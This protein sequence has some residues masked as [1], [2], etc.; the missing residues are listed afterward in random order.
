MKPLA[1]RTNGF[2]FAHKTAFFIAGFLCWQSDWQAGATSLERLKYNN[3]GLVVDLGVGLWAWPLPMDFDGDG[4]LDLV[5]NCPDKPYNGVYFFENTSGD[6]AKNKMPVFKPARR[7]SVGL[8]NVQVSYVAGKPR[9]LSPANEYPD[10]LKTGLASPQTLPLPANVHPNKVRGNFWRYV[11]YDGDGAVDLIVG[12]DDGTDYGWDNAYD[13]TGKWTNGPLRGFVYVA[14]NTGTTEKPGF[15]TPVK[16]M[17]GKKPVEAFGWPSPNF[18]DFD[19]DGDLDLLCG[20]FLD[21]FTYFENVGSRT[22][23]QYAPGRRLKT[24]DGKPLVMDLQMITPTAI[25]WDK[26]GDLDLIVGDEDGR[27]A[28]VENTGKFTTDRTPQFLAPR[29]F[30]QEADDVKCGAL[31]TPVGVDWDGD[32]DWDIVSGNTAGYIVF[33]ENLSGSGVEKPKWAA[34]QFLEADGKIIRI[35]AGPNGS[36]Q[37]PCEAKWGYTT[38]SVADWDGDGLPDIFAN[39]ILGKIHWYRNIGTRGKPKLTA[40]QPI[41]VEWDGSQPKLGYGWLRPEGRA[42]LTQWRT[43]PVA[44]DWNQDGLV[45]LVMLDQ[46]GCLA[47]FERMRLGNKPALRPPK[48]VFHGENFSVTDSRHKVLDRAAGAIRLNNDLAGRSGRRKL[49]VTDWDGDG[50]LD[51]LVNSANANFLR[52]TGARDG[53]FFFRDEGTLAAQNIEGHDVSPTT[54]DFNDDGVPDFLGGA[55]DGRFYYLRNPRSRK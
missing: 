16:V 37:G 53:T 8:Q 4:D 32:G 42:L 1:R 18:A 22:S 12:A 24:L 19:G 36:I 25:D 46:A 15:D 20:E 29:Y 6:T 10:F 51:I 41:E 48:R 30:Q 50:R 9:V 33:F 2:Q 35:M 5:V 45:D 55:E 34:P 49:C 43:T 38:L 39:S 40:A 44:V 23:P 13:A 31:A 7:I 52:Q 54:V 21:G 28:F 3:P 11:D 17:A 47:L 26:D 14:R 27:V